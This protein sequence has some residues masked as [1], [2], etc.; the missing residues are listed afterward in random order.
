MQKRTHTLTR[1]AVAV[2]S[3]GSLALA[4]AAVSA[5]RAGHTATQA[6]AATAPCTAY[7]LP[8]PK[9]WDGQATTMNDAG[10]L[11]GTVVDTHGVEHPAYW[12]PNGSSAADGYQLHQP[13]IP[14]N[15]EFLDVN[16]AG[17]AVAFDDSAG[18]GFVYDI[19]RGSFQ[20]LPDFAGGSADR[21]RRINV[22]GEIAGVALDPDG[23][24]FAAT[25][26]PPYATA[27]RVNAP[28]ENQ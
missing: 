20:Y 13:D 11:V 22:H 12:T 8:A 5:P 27:T 15:G 26:S 21:P 25:W 19:A 16:D 18:R 10:I 9:G 7:E 23:N 28:G 17:V 14:S 2:A 24:G 4:P 6:T 1:A 3:A